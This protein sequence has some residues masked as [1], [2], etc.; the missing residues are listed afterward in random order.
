MHSKIFFLLIAIHGWTQMPVY[1]EPWGKDCD[2][3]MSSSKQPPVH[4][5]MPVAIAHNVILFHQ[6]VLSPVD[7]PRSHFRPSSSEY[8]KGAIDR[9][10]FLKGFFMGCDRLLRENSEAWVYQTIED[11]GQ[12]FKYDPAQLD[13]QTPPS[14]QSR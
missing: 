3:K 7:G 5:T 1:C 11:N 14:F 13:K 8:M 4:H 2:L 6:K 12:I 10:G 9:Y